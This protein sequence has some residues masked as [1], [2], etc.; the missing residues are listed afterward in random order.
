MIATIVGKELNASIILALYH[1][2]LNGFNSWTR[3]G[4]G[5][6]APV[7]F[8]VYSPDVALRVSLPSVVFSEGF[9]PRERNSWC[10]SIVW[11]QPIVRY[12]IRSGVELAGN[13][14]WW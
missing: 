11:Q 6:P 1:L 7:Y 13:G 2:L 10:L 14:P 9:C 3:L 5:C 12:C 8:G 4:I